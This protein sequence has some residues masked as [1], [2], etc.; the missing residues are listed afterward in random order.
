L[1]LEQ[2]ITLS[3]Q[4]WVIAPLAQDD[5]P[6]SLESI[7]RQKIQNLDEESRKLIYQA[8][9]FGEDVP[10]SLLTGSTKIMESKVLEF[11]D[12]AVSQGLMNLDFQVND[13]SLRFRGKRILEI[14][15]EEIQPEEKRELHDQV[16]KYQETLFQ[17]F[18]VPSAAPLIYHFRRA[19]NLEKAKT[20]EQFERVQ[21]LKVFNAAEAFNY[22]GRGEGR[23]RDPRSEAWPQVPSFI[24]CL[25]T[26]C[27]TSS[28]IPGRRGGDHRQPPGEGAVEAILE[29][30][31]TLS[32]F[33]VRRALV[34]N[35][36]K[37]DLSE[38][39]Y[40]G[41]EL[42]K[43]FDRLEVQGIIFRRGISQ[44]E[45][46]LW[47]EAFGRAKPK[48]ID[49]DHWHT[50]S[51]EHHLEHIELKQIRYT[52]QVDAVNQVLQ[53]L[54]PLRES[55]TKIVRF[56]Q[57]CKSWRTGSCGVPELSGPSQCRPEYQALSPAQQ[58]RIRLHRPAEVSMPYSLSGRPGVG[59]GEGLLVVSLSQDRPGGSE[60]Q[61][62]GFVKF[63]DTNLL[64]KLD[65][66][67]RPQPPGIENFISSGPGPSGGSDAGFPR[68]AR[69]RIKT[70]SLIR[71]STRHGD[72][73]PRSEDLDQLVKSWEWRVWTPSFSSPFRKSSWTHSSMI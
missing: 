30:N 60:P 17:K 66:S 56:C 6:K 69:R 28:C 62:D 36:Q 54:Q 67:G 7:I 33:Q 10:L 70:C 14:M 29:K 39:K 65:L 1:V 4:Q 55:G 53:I 40:V 44:W 34:I 73:N 12:Q 51:E 16:G 2:K 15:E 71:S 8:S 49:K 50:F 68:L 57:G 47:L 48:V 35:G 37:V 43:L 9:T 23:P 52:L 72:A 63:L 18:L 61:V 46:N 25:L 27:A 38:L 20:Y 19:S 31:E 42:I 11:V 26:A 21:S 64:S 41:E 5:L 45:V 3:G 22:S 59:P 13:Q 32:L 24:K 58:E